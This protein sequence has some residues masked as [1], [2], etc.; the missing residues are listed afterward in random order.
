M[1]GDVYVNHYVGAFEAHAGAAFV[2]VVVAEPVYDG[3]F[4]A[5]CNKLAVFEF[6][7]VGN[8]IDG[9]C[10]VHIHQCAPVVFLH[11]CIKFVGVSGIERIERLQ[12]SQCRAAAHIGFIQERQI[13]AESD[14]AFTGSYVVGAQC[15]QFVGQYRLQSLEGLGHHIECSCHVSF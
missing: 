14:H 1:V 9:E 12:D 11:F 2:L 5:I 6:G 8:G 10:L 4:H 15:P 3:I 7:A 13:A